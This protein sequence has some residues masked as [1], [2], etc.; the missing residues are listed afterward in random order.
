VPSVGDK[1]PQI[2]PLRG[3]APTQSTFHPV[4]YLCLQCITIYKVSL[5]TAII[6]ANYE[7]I[8]IHVCYRHHTYASTVKEHMQPTKK[9]Y[10]MVVTQTKSATDKELKIKK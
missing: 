5:L 1:N 10:R 8:D 6:S 9:A 2:S 3:V 4:F 7:L